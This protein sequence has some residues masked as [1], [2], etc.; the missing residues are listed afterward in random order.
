MKKL[1]NLKWTDESGPFWKEV[2]T[3]MTFIDRDDV[4]VF[5]AVERSYEQVNAFVS[6]TSMLENLRFLFG[7]TVVS[8]EAVEQFHDQMLSAYQAD[9]V[10]DLIEQINDPDEP[11]KDE[12]CLTA[13]AN[14]LFFHNSRLDSEEWLETFQNE[15]SAVGWSD[16]TKAELPGTQELYQI[17]REL[18]S[19]EALLKD[20]AFGHADNP[21]Y[22]AFQQKQIDEIR[23]QIDTEAYEK[24]KTEYL[25]EQYNAKKDREWV[26]MP[27]TAEWGG[28]FFMTDYKE[29][30]E[31]LI[32]M[33]KLTSKVDIGTPRKATKEE[34]LAAIAKGR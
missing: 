20:P 9:S 28:S 23:S 3:E 7:S 16:Q 30:I 31:F 29:E 19:A 21:E 22:P 24:W 27:Y 6:R 17:Y 32:E 8:P 18:L 2:L 14:D 4:L 10:A 12:I 33:L 1:V 26:T 11:Y 5:A 25:E 34:I 13:M 15:G